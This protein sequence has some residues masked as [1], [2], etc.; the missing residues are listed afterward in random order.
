MKICV[1]QTRPIKGDIQGNIVAHQRLVE[2]AAAYG[3]ETVIFPEL[4]LTGYEPTLAQA[5]A[6][7]QDDA[8]LDRLQKTADCRQMTIGVGLPTVNEPLPSISMVIFQPNQPRQLYSKQFLHGDEEPFFTSGPR[9][10]G[11]VGRSPQVALAICYELSVA[12]HAAQAVAKGADLCISVAKSAR[13]GEPG[14]YTAQ[15]MLPAIM[16]CGADEQL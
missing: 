3:A 2:R 5:L 12:A 14:G 7:H 10:A 13:W 16:G 8:R 1:V 4:S 11:L 6:T 9:S 15:Q